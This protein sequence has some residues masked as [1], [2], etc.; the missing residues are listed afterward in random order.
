MEQMADV[1]IMMTGARGTIL[2]KTSLFMGGT[3][4]TSKG[5]TNDR[6]AT[7]MLTLVRCQIA[8]GI[9]VCD[10]KTI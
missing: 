9:Y 5:T 10:P 7:S 8:L 3:N 2:Q 1:W 4:L 6:M